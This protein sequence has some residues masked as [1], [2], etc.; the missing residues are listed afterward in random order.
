MGAPLREND[1]PSLGSGVA[2]VP[3][4]VEATLIECYPANGFHQIGGVDL[5]IHRQGGEWLTEFRPGGFLGFPEK[6]GLA[7]T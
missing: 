7:L 5:L 6:V 1:N 3:G 2:P 4:I